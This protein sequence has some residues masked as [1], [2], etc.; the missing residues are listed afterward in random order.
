MSQ[1]PQHNVRRG[2]EID[3]GMVYNE[4]RGS[5]SSPSQH[6]PIHA[7]L[8][9]SEDQTMRQ[10]SLGTIPRKKR[11]FGTMQDGQGSK[12][13]L[14]M[15][16][17]RNR[18]ENNQGTWNGPP[19]KCRAKPDKLKSTRNNKVF[20]CQKC[21]FGKGKKTNH[22]TA[23]HDPDYNKKTK[24]IHKNKNTINNNQRSRQI[25]GVSGVL[26]R[27]KAVLP[28]NRS[29]VN[30]DSRTSASN[31]TLGY[32]PTN[33]Y[34][35]NQNA[36]KICSKRKLNTNLNESP[37]ETKKVLGRSARALGRSARALGEDQ[38]ENPP[39][40]CPIRKSNSSKIITSRPTVANHQ[41]ATKNNTIATKS[42]S[43]FSHT[44]GA[45]PKLG[46]VLKHFGAEKKDESANTTVTRKEVT[47]VDDISK[48]SL[49]DSQN[50]KQLQ[51]K[52]S[53]GCA[54]GAPSVTPDIRTR[55]EGE[56][57]LKKQLD[58]KLSS[59][60]HG[61]IALSSKN[62]KISSF[63]KDESDSLNKIE[64]AT[65]RE[66]QPLEALLTKEIIHRKINNIYVTEK[67]TSHK[68]TV[69][70]TMNN[71]NKEI[72]EKATC[73]ATIERSETIGDQLES[74]KATRN[75]TNT[76]RI[77]TKKLR[78]PSVND[79]S[80]VNVQSISTSKEEN[81]TKEHCIL[82]E[83]DLGETSTE[84]EQESILHDTVNVSSCEP[85]H[86]GD[87]SYKACMSYDDSSF[88]QSSSPKFSISNETQLS[89]SRTSDKSSLHCAST[90]AG[91]NTV[92]FSAIS[93]KK[94]G[95]ND[96]INRQNIE[97]FATPGDPTA[98]HIGTHS[99]R[100]DRPQHITVTTSSR[101][102]S[103]VTE[104]SSSSISSRLTSNE[105]TLQSSSIHDDYVH[106]QTT[107]STVENIIA[108]SNKEDTIHNTMNR[109][110]SP[111]SNDEDLSNDDKTS[112]F[113]HSLRPD[114]ANT[115]E[116]P[117]SIYTSD[118][119]KNINNCN[120]K[121]SANAYYVSS[122]RRITGKIHDVDEKRFLEAK[123]DYS[124]KEFLKSVGK[125]SINLLLST[126]V[127]E[128]SASYEEWRR[129]HRNEVVLYPS[130]ICAG[131]QTLARTFKNETQGKAKTTELERTNVKPNRYVDES[132]SINET[133]HYDDER[134]L[135]TKLN[136]SAKEFLKHTGKCSI[137]SLLSVSITELAKSYKEYRR[138]HFNDDV[139]SPY[140]TCAKW[141][142]LVRDYQDEINR[143][144]EHY[145][146]PEDAK[147][148][149]L[150]IEVEHLTR[151]TFENVTLL[152]I[153][154][155]TVMDNRTEQL[156]SFRINIRQS[157]IPDSGYG[158]FLTFLGAR[159]LK[160][161]ARILSEKLMKDR[162]EFEEFY[163]ENEEPPTL[164]AVIGDY[165]V[166]VTLTGQ[167]LHGNGNCTYFSYTRFPLKAKLYDKIQN[168]FIGPNEV[169]DDVQALRS[170]NE[171]ASPENGL[172]KL[173]MFTDDD[174]ESDDETQFCSIDQGTIDLGRYGPFLLT[175]RK[176]EMEFNLKDFLFDFEPAAWNFHVEEK[177]RGCSQFIDVTDDCTGEPHRLACSNIP[178]YVN[179]VGH[180]QTL[181]QNVV[182]R[183]Q[184]NRVVHYYINQHEPMSKGD[185]V[186]L[187][188]NYGIGYEGTRERKGYG[189]E[190]IEGILECDK[191]EIAKMKRDHA[192]REYMVDTIKNMKLMKIKHYVEF[193]E[194]RFIAPLVEFTDAYI[195]KKRNYQRIPSRRQLAARQRLSWLGSLF[196]RQI[197]DLTVGTTF[198][199][200]RDVQNLRKLL[201]HKRLEPQI[202]LSDKSSPL[203]TILIS[204]RYEEVL[205]S[206][207]KEDGLFHAYDPSMWSKVGR[208]FCRDFIKTVT[209]NS[210]G[211]S[212]TF[213][214]LI[215]PLFKM[216]IQAIDIIKNACNTLN[217]A[218][219][220]Q[221]DIS[222][223]CEVLGLR[224]TE[225]DVIKTFLQQ[226]FKQNSKQVYLLPIN[227]GT[228]HIKSGFRRSYVQSTDLLCSSSALSDAGSS[229]SE[230]PSY[231][232]I[233]RCISTSDHCT[234][235]QWRDALSSKALLVDEEWYIQW[236]VVRVFHVLW[237]NCVHESTH[238][239]IHYSI[240]KL[241]RTLGTNTDDAKTVISAKMTQPYEK[242]HPHCDQEEAT[243][244]Q[245]TEEKSVTQGIGKGM[246]DHRT[247]KHNIKGKNKTGAKRNSKAK[248]PLYAKEDNTLPSG[249]RLDYVKRHTGRHVDRYWYTKTNKKLR[250]RIEVKIFLD[251]V[252]L[253]NGDEDKA[254]EA[255]PAHRKKLSGSPPKKVTNLLLDK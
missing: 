57:H 225:N 61:T 48:P 148:F 189:K 153:K 90:T 141:Q 42:N 41:N 12:P 109:Q 6:K 106:A 203:I 4:V 174:Y 216:A 150:M 209:L 140:A 45:V 117:S 147:D 50:M 58:A 123:F 228:N 40:P 38:M 170:R 181:K 207:S 107:S 220:T 243:E 122:R 104:L 223:A 116:S 28:N 178:K 159:K 197:D 85:I 247:K 76:A 92:E 249:W 108:D 17:S 246:N 114:S 206:V 251:L 138:L 127:E 36:T 237:I 255:Y 55:Q 221:E 9:T 19:N 132:S 171:I 245:K 241:C 199:D 146:D 143:N 59:I 34:D 162:L 149:S 200:S 196:R 230:S 212:S 218:N 179:E 69:G 235:S 54:V 208:D 191:V 56:E 134:F 194:S 130:A 25:H 110:T 72:I 195:R 119:S 227:L 213:G 172:G 113:E 49:L 105:T 139:E 240:E 250:S 229:L 70:G 180:D 99:P 77:R 234:F 158:A 185:T 217:S 2:S 37:L 188:V 74:A 98:G 198:Q 214:R 14:I 101:L 192:E 133:G 91:S 151:V 18:W 211:R 115:F 155:I 145:E 136:T 226:S 75:R 204:E 190:N 253:H 32:T 7:E 244:Y 46:S 3:S 35:S 63:G 29:N 242:I 10:K 94:H 51:Q 142:S 88:S 22:T 21:N 169:H 166:I 43:L 126:P 135:E 97:A 205:C 131:W 177:L 80:N 154:H 71:K 1:N 165:N 120:D 31:G 103:N 231:E 93:N 224:A 129:Q 30:K 160:E 167:D 219:S 44:T 5:R 239:N 84:T 184:H 137:E 118:F 23:E 52:Q 152:P 164:E 81:V 163:D 89:D 82:N 187:L 24:K 16:S 173:K 168:V 238:S 210:I 95:S 13:S 183:D 73:K 175:D 215:D 102:P 83:R 27:Q 20:W 67:S 79:N 124:V 144:K 254:W 39:V 86:D 26:A 125:F 156:F 157:G 176:T 11:D 201:D 15:T 78:T 96:T 64:S 62:G 87:N 232:S 252:S 111:I 193:L 236:Q 161:R 53:L 202:S 60:D 68:N 233:L 112:F 100:V 8:N 33:K 47:N 222:K 65:H 186:E 66:D 182:A 248:G 128:L 121:S